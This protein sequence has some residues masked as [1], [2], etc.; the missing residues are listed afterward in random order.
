M[1]AGITAQLDCLVDDGATAIVQQR[2][3]EERANYLSMPKALP[4]IIG[5]QIW[6]V[7]LVKI[8]LWSVKRD[9]SHIESSLERTAT[10]DGYLEHELDDAWIKQNSL[11][12]VKQDD[13]GLLF[14]GCRSCPGVHL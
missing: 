1:N 14:S 13:F 8:K 2:L 7:R 12:S 5:Q 3:F 6:N 4:S 11:I 9:G 10:C